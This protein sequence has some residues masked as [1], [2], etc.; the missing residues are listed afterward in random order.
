MSNTQKNR[1]SAQLFMLS[2][3]FW[4]SILLA[5][6]LW[7]QV[8]HLMAQ[9]ITMGSEYS[10]L[11]QGT[12][13][14]LLFMMIVSLLAYR[15]KKDRTQILLGL[16]FLLFAAA[17]YFSESNFI[18]NSWQPIFGAV[19]IIAIVWQLLKTDLIA[20]LFV[21]C[22]CAALIMAMLGDMWHDHPEVLIDWVPIYHVGRIAYSLEEYLDLWGIAFFAYA[23]LFV[24]RDILLVLFLN[25]RLSM[26]MLILSAGFIASGNSFAHWQYGHGETMIAIAT[27]MAFLGL[28]GMALANERLLIDSMQFGFFNKDIFYYHGVLIFLI[29][30]VIYGGLSGVL[31]LIMW[32]CFFILAGSYLY[33]SNPR[34][35]N[36]L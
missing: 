28:L 24:F 2:A 20:L 14:L 1:N 33:K 10:L 7:G 21:C 32:V 16:T 34:L 25:N 30:P 12:K 17:M 11:E 22:G 26:A 5:S 36:K 31:N 3:F 4:V 27:A 15:N 13:L 23:N 19:F 8:Y 9:F 35:Y 18:E 29:L 6:V